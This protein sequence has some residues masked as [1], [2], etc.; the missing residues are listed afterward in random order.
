M[1]ESN[2]FDPRGFV[3]LSPEQTEEFAYNLAL[4]LKV[5]A[6]NG[7]VVCLDG[8]LGAGKTVFAKGFARGL[9]VSDE[10][11]SPTFSIVNVYQ[12]GVPFHHFDAY[13]IVDVSEMEETNYEEYFYGGGVSLVEWAENIK[14]LIPEGAVWVT[15]SKDLAR[16][17][18]Y[19]KIT[20][21]G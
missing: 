20:V 12:G 3:S 11:T 6:E 14:G 21:K 1:I 5:G 16:G 18:C 8:E 7:A 19:R 10:I 9:G 2:E 15:I 17:E 4:R 13:R